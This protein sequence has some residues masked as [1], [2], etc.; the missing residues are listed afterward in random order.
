MADSTYSFGAQANGDR[1]YGG[2]SLGSNVSGAR[3]QVLEDLGMKGLSDMSF[4]GVKI[5]RLGSMAKWVA[6]LI[7]SLTI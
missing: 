2:S 3:E 6:S 1:K 5:D 4:Q 7:E